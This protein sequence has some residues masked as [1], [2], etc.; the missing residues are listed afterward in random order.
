MNKPRS[1]F[2]RVLVV[3]F[4]ICN[5]L[6]ILNHSTA[7]FLIMYAR[8]E[9]A[10]IAVAVAIATGGPVKNRFNLT[11]LSYVPARFALADVMMHFYKPKRNVFPLDSRRKTD[12]VHSKAVL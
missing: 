9:L 11:E 3:T 7:V 8:L 10:V 6:Q 4:L 5:N 12:G 1:L 2:E